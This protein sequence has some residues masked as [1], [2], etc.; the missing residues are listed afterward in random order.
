MSAQQVSRVVGL[1]LEGYISYISTFNELTSYAPKY[2]KNRDWTGMQQVHKR[3]LRL[4]KYEVNAT[5]IL[6]KG[7]LREEIGQRQLWR[8]VKANFA[9][10]ITTRKDKEL[11]ESFFNSVVRKTVPDTAVDEE[12]MF[13]HEGYDTCDIH[14]QETL[15]H[16]YPPRWGLQKIMRKIVEDFDFEAPYLDKEAD[17]QY[18]VQAV[19]SI[20]LTRYKPDERTITQVLKSV[21]YRNK[22]AYLIGRTFVGEK[23]MPFVIPFMHGP[24]GIYVD[25]LIFE[26]NLMSGLFSYTRSYFMVETAIPSQMISFLLAVIN[27]KKIHELYNAIGFNKHGK[28]E[29]Y[30]DFIGHLE[31]SKDQFIL[32]RA[33]KAWS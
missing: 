18:L 2:F 8:E 1:M 17:V 24:R 19:R 3:R 12:I 7:V 5:R 23:W 15:Y 16:T 25:T 33:S 21:F 14:P 26:K 31:Q 28:T 9:W 20:V 4:Y 13:V 10:E 30:R 22:A 27:H 11:A 6:I 32:A 29:F